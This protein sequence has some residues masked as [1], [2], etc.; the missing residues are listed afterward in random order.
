MRMESQERDTGKGRD[1]QGSRLAEG[2]MMD[3]RGRRGI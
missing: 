1:D 2:D 3:E